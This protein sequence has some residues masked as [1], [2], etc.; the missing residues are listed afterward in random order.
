[1]WEEGRL[2][3]SRVVRLA[4]LA[5]IVVLAVDLLVNARLSA[6]FD[7][8]FVA[9]CLACALAVRPRDFAGV[10]ML[11][12][13]LLVGTVAAL[14][15]VDTSWVAE[16]SDGWVQALVSGITHRATGLAV[17]YGLLLLVLL[18]RMRVR[19]R[20]AHSNREGS[21]A[22]TRATSG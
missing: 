18:V 2:T 17:G 4:V 7:V 16:S 20:R 14:A 3:V 13:L 21:P 8:A 1:M 9:I 6:L 19:V 15:A 11:P 12:P 10:A 5:S 22:P